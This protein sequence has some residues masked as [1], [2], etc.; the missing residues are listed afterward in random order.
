MPRRK[1]RFRLG[2]ALGLLLAGAC[3][4]TPT[5]EESAKP[6][7]AAGSASVL[8]AMAPAATPPAPAS[9][10]DAS[11]EA[12]DTTG[13]R[14]GRLLIYSAITG[15]QPLA[16][17]QRPPDAD[18]YATPAER[19]AAR[20]RAIEAEIASEVER[21]EQF[22]VRETQ[23]APSPAVASGGEN[24]LE[25]PIPP[26]LE[27]LP[28]ALFHEEEV[29]IAAGVWQNVGAL[30]LLRR[31]LDADGDDRPEEVRFVDPANG[32]IVRSEHDTDF[33]GLAD[34]WVSYANG[35]PALQVRDEDGDGRN[36]RWERFEA[37]GRSARTLDA[38]RDGVKDRFFR[39]GPEGL[40]EALYDANDDKSVDRIERYRGGHRIRSEEDQD[41]DGTMDT[42]TDFGFAEGNEV[43]ERIERRPSAPGQPY[44]VEIYRS[45]GGRTQ[46]VQRQED[47]DRDGR[48]DVVSTYENG[49]LVQRA[50]SDEALS[51]L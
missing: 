37:D 42:F 35:R 15:H 1:L 25:P 33:D 20:A 36:D 30:Q 28:Q 48:A 10:P 45:E 11:G 51:P 32:E 7:A 49:K 13:A 19:E 16:G 6:H 31:S 43:V 44:S 21:R 5:P 26:R 50:I 38:N 12:S 46:L 39:Y 18:R 17:G 8:R 14:P 47:H 2:A 9:E 4:G 3:A 29:T 41:L 22:E 40:E 34:R 23:A 27:D 24:P